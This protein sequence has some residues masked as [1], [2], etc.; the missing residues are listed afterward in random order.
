MRA[1]IV[2]TG[3]A[4][5]FHAAMLRR[6]YGISVELH[7]VYSR[8]RENRDEFA[9]RWSTRSTSSLGELIDSCDVVHVCVPAAHHESVTAAALRADRNVI[10]E[11]PFTGAFSKGADPSSWTVGDADEAERSAYESIVRL[12][13]A[14]RGSKGRVGYAENWVFAPGVKKEAEIIRK[15]GAQLLWIHGEESHSGSHSSVYGSRAHSGGGS[16]M[17][18]GVHPL[19]AA[20]FLKRCS[21][22]DQN[23]QP[24]A[25]SSRTHRVTSLPGFTDKGFVRTDYYDVEDWGSIHVV[26]NDGT[27]A[28]LFASEIVVGGVHN[29]LSVVANNHRTEIKINPNDALKT[30]N[31]AGPQFED[32]YTVEK[33]ETKEGWV[34]A[35][36]DEDWFTGYQAEMQSMYESFAA[37]TPLVSDSL[38]GAQTILTVYAGYRSAARDGVQVAIRSLL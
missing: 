25:V 15:S 35:S 8:N 9:G 33:I 3:F 32:I 12:L 27:F 22:G 7:S 30:F 16:L 1:G 6:V 5:E 23:A 38:L 4:A 29:W 28:D 21:T 11:K 20:L 10:L 37:T 17:G 19:T 26:F 31:P 24:A 13:E 34:E 14:E 18:K 2:G 36:A